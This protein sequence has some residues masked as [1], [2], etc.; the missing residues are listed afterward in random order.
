MQAIE[1]TR[2]GGTTVFVGVAG[3]GPG[4]ALPMMRMV[5]EDRTIKGSYYGSGAR[6]PRLPALHRPHRDGSRRPRRDGHEALRARN[7]ESGVGRDAR[8][9]GRARRLDELVILRPV[10]HP[11]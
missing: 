2:R 6:C 7:G 10:T 3:R 1:M 4:L 5:M 8:R 11:R 9:R